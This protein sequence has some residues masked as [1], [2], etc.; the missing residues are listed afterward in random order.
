[1]LSSKLATKIRFRLK[2]FNNVELRYWCVKRTLLYTYYTTFRD[3]TRQTG[4]FQET[5]IEK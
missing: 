3:E 4:Y 5:A 1:M 2:A